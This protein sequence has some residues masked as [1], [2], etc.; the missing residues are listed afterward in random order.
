MDRNVKRLFV[1]LHRK[2]EPSHEL[3]A[4]Y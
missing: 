1:Q 4:N 2:D 3:T